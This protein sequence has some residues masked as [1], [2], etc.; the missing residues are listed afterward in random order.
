LQ[1]GDYVEIYEDNKFQTNSQDTR[2]ILA[3]TLNP[4]YNSTGSYNFF[5]LVTGRTVERGSWTQRPMPNWVID[6]VNNMGAAEGRPWTTIVD[7]SIPGKD[8]MPP[9]NDFAEDD[10]NPTYYDDDPKSFLD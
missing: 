8:N 6:R 7:F 5:S 1:F 10:N 4:V 9:L 2:G 3:I